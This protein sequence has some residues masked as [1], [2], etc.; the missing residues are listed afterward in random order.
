MENYQLYNEYVVLV[1]WGLTNDSPD[2]PTR[3]L[4]QVKIKVLPNTFCENIIYNLLKDNS[5]IDDKFLCTKGEPHALTAPV[6]NVYLSFSLLIV[7]YNTFFF[8][9]VIVEDQFCLRIM[10]WV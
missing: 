7:I 8:F 4:Q 6:S 2:R 3:Y 1:G 5:T 10:S 9:R